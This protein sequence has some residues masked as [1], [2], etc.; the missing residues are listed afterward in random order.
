MGLF[1]YSRSRVWIHSF[2]RWN[3]RIRIEVPI[4]NKNKDLLNLY[5]PN[6][7]LL[8]DNVQKPCIWHRVQAVS[9]EHCFHLLEAVL[10][11]KINWIFFYIFFNLDVKI[12]CWTVGSTYRSPLP[13]WKA[14]TKG[15][16][17]DS[18]IAH[19]AND[20]TLS[21]VATKF[22]N[23]LKVSDPSFALVRLYIFYTSSCKVIG[24]SSNHHKTFH[25]T[26]FPCKLFV[27]W[28]TFYDISHFRSVLFIGPFKNISQRYLTRHINQGVGNV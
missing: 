7:T 20:F 10:I 18:F 27:C 1:A 15:S 23:R 22:L 19:F 3:K 2:W 25:S 9:L 5:S 12:F 17:C 24:F 11:S 13:F 16:Q 4:R 21:N 6:E 14:L 8:K 26:P 28:F